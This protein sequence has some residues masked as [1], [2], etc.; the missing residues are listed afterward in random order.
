MISLLL[1]SVL[2]TCKGAPTIEPPSIE[3]FISGWSLAGVKPPETPQ[4]NYALSPRVMKISANIVGGS[5]INAL[6]WDLIILGISIYQDNDLA[7]KPCLWKTPYAY[8]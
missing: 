2:C 6:P 4:T 7:F 1:L 8:F 3:A 5:P